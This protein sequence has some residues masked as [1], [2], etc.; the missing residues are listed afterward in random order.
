MLEALTD[1]DIAGE[2]R[3]FCVARIVD[4]R[5][6]RSRSWSGGLDAHAAAGNEALDV[7]RAALAVVDDD[8]GGPRRSVPCA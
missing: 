5:G 7:G 2:S 6:R 8:L 3:S 1:H 4:W